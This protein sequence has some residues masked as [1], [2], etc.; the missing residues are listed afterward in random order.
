MSR[1]A[2][3]GRTNSGFPVGGPVIKNKV[4]FFGDYEGFRRVQGT[5]LTGSVPTAPSE[6]A[7]IPISP[8]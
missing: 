8:I 7:G 4:F 6:A 3:C 2:N 1:R 5:I